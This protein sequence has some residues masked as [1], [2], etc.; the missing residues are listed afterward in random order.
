MTPEHIENLVRQYG[1]GLR[2]AQAARRS[3]QLD[4]LSH[5]IETTAAAWR[6]AKDVAVAFNA[7]KVDWS[8]IQ[9]EVAALREAAFSPVQELVLAPEDQLAAK[10]ANVLAGPPQKNAARIN[11]LL[12]STWFGWTEKQKTAL[13]WLQPLLE[14]VADLHDV[15]PKLNALVREISAQPPSGET[16]VARYREWQKRQKDV[17]KAI[18]KVLP[19]AVADFLQSALAGGAWLDTLS[20]VALAWLSSHGLAAHLKVSFSPT[21]N[22]RPIAPASSQGADAQAEHDDWV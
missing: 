10:P 17:L 12:R 18:D 7:L 15:A 14:R 5:A 22:P 6:S 4:M 8:A 13:T 21:P 19:P 3:Q 9:G 20:E 2:A 16:E 11:E 1:A